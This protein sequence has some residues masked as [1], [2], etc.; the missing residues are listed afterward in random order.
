MPHRPDGE[1]RA[2]YRGTLH[3]LIVEDHPDG[4]E[5][6]R[7]LL[8]MHGYRVDV[9]KDGVEGVEKGLT[10]APDVAIID[11]GLPLLDGYQV[12]RRLRAGL[13]DRIKL[14]ACTA[15]S[16]PDE[17]QNARDAGFDAFLPKPADPDEL[18]RLLAEVARR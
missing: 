15:Y 11:I 2:A 3:L 5:S 13:G 18:L 10:Q 7:L 14:F 1:A 16:R 12:A 17:V 6:L 8:E 9:A 4:R